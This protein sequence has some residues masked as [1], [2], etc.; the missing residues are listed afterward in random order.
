MKNKVE[1]VDNYL[2]KENFKIIEEI[3]GSSDFA[4]FYC[5]HVATIRDTH[6][7]L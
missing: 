5:P 6:G 3:T 1:I 7:N 2:S 4:W